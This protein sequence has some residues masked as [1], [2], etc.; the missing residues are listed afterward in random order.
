MTY[1]FS[2]ICTCEYIYRYHYRVFPVKH[3]SI[4]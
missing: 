2:C 3:F 4:L 1:N